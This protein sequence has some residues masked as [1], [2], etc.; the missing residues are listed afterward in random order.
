MENKIGNKREGGGCVDV[1]II[2]PT[3]IVLSGNLSSFFSDLF[4]CLCL[5]VLFNV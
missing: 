4:M 3:S 2:I 1:L 5:C